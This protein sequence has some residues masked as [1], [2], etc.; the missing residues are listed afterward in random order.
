[1]SLIGWECAQTIDG[2][3]NLIY[4]PNLQSGEWGF[5]SFTQWVKFNHKI[6]IKSEMTSQ[7]YVVVVRSNQKTD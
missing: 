5:N 1:M 7:M 4:P 3:I 6:L 2:S